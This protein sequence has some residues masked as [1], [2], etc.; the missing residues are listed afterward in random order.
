MSFISEFSRALITEQKEKTST[1][2]I[3]MSHHTFLNT[4]GKCTSFRVFQEIKKKK[5]IFVARLLL[6]TPLNLSA[7]FFFVK[8]E[9]E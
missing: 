1:G 4:K 9:N 7:I 3:K 6:R 2:T 8:K 5:C